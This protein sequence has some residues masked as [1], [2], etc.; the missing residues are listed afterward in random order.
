[1]S[2]LTTLRPNPTR[3]GAAGGNQTLPAGS[4]TDEPV[5]AYVYAGAFAFSVG[6]PDNDMDGLLVEEAMDY[7]AAAAALEKARTI[8]E[9]DFPVGGPFGA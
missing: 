9:H 7:E 2:P 8:E 1:M 3:S 5:E 4:S 6:A